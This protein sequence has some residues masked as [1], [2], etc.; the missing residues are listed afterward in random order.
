MFGSSADPW[1]ISEKAAVRQ[2]VRTFDWP[3]LGICL[4]HQLL[5][6]ALGGEVSRAKTPEA[7]LCNIM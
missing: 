5:A 4:G 2:W 1:L 3:M 7:D 6:D